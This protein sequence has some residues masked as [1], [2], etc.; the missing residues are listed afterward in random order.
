VRARATHD[1]I[2]FNNKIFFFATIV[3]HPGAYFTASRKNNR[4]K[5]KKRTVL[6]PTQVNWYNSTKE[7]TTIVKELGKMYR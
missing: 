2:I 5:L 1:E 4:E 3:M 7:G 6:N